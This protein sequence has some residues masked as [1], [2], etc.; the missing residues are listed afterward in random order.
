MCPSQGSLGSA[1]GRGHDAHDASSHRPAHRTRSEV[2]PG[3]GSKN[4]EG[5]GEATAR[6]PKIRLVTFASPEEEA[7]IGRKRFLLR[8]KHKSW[9][10]GS[11]NR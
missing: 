1:H 7:K 9:G 5:E 4:R 8:R 2:E 10:S 11:E 3:R 6:F